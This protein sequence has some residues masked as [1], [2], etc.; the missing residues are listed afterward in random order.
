MTRPRGRSEAL[1]ECVRG[2][3]ILRD[4]PISR[5]ARAMLRR[6]GMKLSLGVVA[7]AIALVACSSDSSGTGAS[8]SA[9]PSTSST[10]SLPGSS[11]G[12]TAVTG[13]APETENLAMY[14]H[15]PPNVGK[16]PPIVLALHGCT[17]G[18]SD[19]VNAGWNDLADKAGFVVVYGEQSASNNPLRCF[20]WWDP[21]HTTRD[22]G[23]AKAL[24][25]MVANA[26]ATYGAGGKVYVTGL[27]AGAAM[28]AVMLA[29]YPDVFDAGAIMAGDPY[30]C[31]TSEVDAYGC[32]NPGKTKTADEWKAL[33]PSVPGAKAPRV[34]IWQGDA[35]FTV[36]PENEQQLVLQWTAVNGA[37]STATA[38]E[39]VGKATH[40][41]YGDDVESW[42]I[43]G[44][45]HGVSIAPKSG[46]GTAAA[47]VLDEDLCSTS[48]A[49]E[50]F[51]LV[52]ASGAPTAPQPAGASAP[53]R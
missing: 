9:C 20:R 34:S 36:R 33:V 2:D 43:A 19:Y 52:T 51:G 44:M 5:V 28:T 39:T 6:H 10:Q 29:T 8:P 48:K 4:R 37:S 53:C 38:T 40:A 15:A 12:L 1:R 30:G 32:T 18:A 25:A 49:A 27:S 21:A 46:C 14:V 7:A 16:D 50:F 13:F 41:R 35:D 22:K 17:Q 45:G 42:V 11:G 31:A 26:R 47:F 23:E 24:A 3:A